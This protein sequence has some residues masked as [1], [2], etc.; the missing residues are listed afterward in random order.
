MFDV[1]II[2]GGIIGL[3]TAL[4]VISENP[5]KKIAVLEKESQFACHQTGHNSGVI[6]SGI[7]YKPGSLKAK[8]CKEGVRLLLEFCEENQ[9][10]Y[11]LCGKLIV[12]TE[13][14]ELPHLEEL[15]RRGKANQVPGLRIVE[16]E[17]IHEIEPAV[18]GIK[19]L[20][21]PS[22]G[23]VNYKLIAKTYAKNFQKLGGELFLEREVQKIENKGNEIRISTKDQEF[24]T[25]KLINCGGLFSDRLTKAAGIELPDAQILPFRGEYYD[26]HPRKNHLV[27]GL[28]YPVPN[29]KYPFLGVHLTRTIDGKIDV[30]PNAVLAYAREGYKK[31]TINLADLAE[32]FQYK[33]FWKMAQKNWKM[34]LQETFRSFSKKAFLKEVQ[35]LVP[36]LTENDLLPGDTGVRAQVVTHTGDMCHDF[37]ILSEENMTHVLNAPSPGATSSLSIGKSI[38]ALLKTP[39]K[40][41]CKK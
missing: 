35:R 18:Q 13:K 15:E 2:G 29:P 22:A 3:A 7:Y 9:I 16:R 34:G 17:E 38:A 5:S 25:K 36:E 28:I 26:L 39:K 12:A 37:Y 32:M 14:E 24:V 33:G 20:Y 8:N 11:E 40:N 19:A 4:Q 6:H 31:S 41:L 23:I 27:K 10:P 1:I 30:G 21:S